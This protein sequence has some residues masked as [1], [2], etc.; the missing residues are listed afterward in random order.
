MAH[1]EIAHDSKRHDF[2]K[3]VLKLLLGEILDSM[4]EKHILEAGEQMTQTFTF[5]CGYQGRV[6]FQLD[7]EGDC[8]S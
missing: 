7:F 4:H 6:I 2:S 8:G 1:A 5:D 3:D